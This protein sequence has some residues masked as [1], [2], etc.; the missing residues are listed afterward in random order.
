[1][2]EFSYDLQVLREAVAG[3]QQS[4]QDMQSIGQT[5][6]GPDFEIPPAAFTLDDKG[7]VQIYQ[8]AKQDMQQFLT[9]LESRFADMVTTLNQVIQAYQGAESTNSAS[10]HTMNSQLGG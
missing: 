10:L 4:T 6:A 8:S 9:Q 1:M 5:I 7:T 3:L 2:T